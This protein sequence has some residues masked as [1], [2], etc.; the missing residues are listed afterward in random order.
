TFYSVREMDEDGSQFASG[1]GS[2]SLI[3]V[4][5]HANYIPNL[6]KRI[7]PLQVPCVT[8]QTILSQHGMRQLDVLVIDAEGFD[9]EILKSIDFDKVRPTLIFFE[10]IHLKPNE[11]FECYTLLKRVGYEL[12]E[13]HANTLALQAGF[14]NEH[15]AMTEAW[16]T[17]Q[18]MTQE[19]PPQ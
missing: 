9:G 14:C 3:H 16:Q 11:R 19:N 6:V 17:A 4:L 12:L 15:T 10:Q 1:I 2:F 5:R 8:V 7:E 13:H 18:A